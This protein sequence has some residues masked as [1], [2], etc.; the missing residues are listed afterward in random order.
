MKK[1]CIL[2]LA[3]LAFMFI[4]TL[5]FANAQDYGILSQPIKLK[6]LASFFGV[7]AQ[8]TWGDLIIVIIVFV[9]FAIAFS[10]IIINF[11]A[12]SAKTSWVIG[13]CLAIIGVL[14][15]SCVTVAHLLMTITVWAGTL[16]VFIAVITA[17][18]AFALLH[19]G[20]D[21]FGHWLKRRQA[22]VAT[23]GAI[24]ETQSGM[25]YLRQTGREAARKR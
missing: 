8:A 12:F 9:I 24:T 6:W 16:S 1:K 5:A 7:G 15:K 21:R 3:L 10:D 19:L 13:I 20:V 14:T 18:V 22:W 23:K 2:I 4:S 17:F 25:R 11:T